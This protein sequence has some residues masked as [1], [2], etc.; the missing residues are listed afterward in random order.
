MKITPRIIALGLVLVLAVP[1]IYGQ[2]SDP[3]LRIGAL[4]GGLVYDAAVAPMG[5]SYLR[6]RALPR[7]HIQAELDGGLLAPMRSAPRLARI[8]LRAVSLPFERPGRPSGLVPYASLGSGMVLYHQPPVSKREAEER[9]WALAFPAHVGLSV[10]L[11]YRLSLDVEGGYVLLTSG[12]TDFFPRAAGY[13]TFGFGLSVIDRPPRPSEAPRL[14]PP[15]LDPT[16]AP[17]PATFAVSSSHAQASDARDDAP[18]LP[19]QPARKPWPLHAADVSIP[20]IV[21][22]AASATPRMPSPSPA[23]PLTD[24]AIPTPPEAVVPSTP[25]PPADPISKDV[26]AEIDPYLGGWT[27][28]V[29]SAL[30]RAEAEAALE[31][32]RGLGHPLSVLPSL[33]NGRRRYRVALGQFAALEELKSARSQ[34]ATHIP[35][36]AWALR[37]TLDP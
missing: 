2:T 16:P 26:P 14:S 21:L 8:G 19:S 32:Y 6:F 30:S 29:Y 17:V 10:R 12:T 7:L 1:S 15:L 34:L 37:L 25:L 27:L 35:S 31:P 24:P 5:H 22:T 3:G 33:Y 36:D 4:G 23:S 11:G 13:W 18:P 28:V 9:G 20:E